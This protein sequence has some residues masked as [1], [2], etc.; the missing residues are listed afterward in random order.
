LL[1]E[2]KDEEN[3]FH[4][5]L[6]ELQIKDV[7]IISVSGKENFRKEY[8][9][10]VK[11]SG[12]TSV[13][14]IG[15]VRDAEEHPAESSFASICSIIKKNTPA[16]IVPEKPGE[17]KECNSYKTGIYIMPDCCSSGM[18]ED[19][20]IASIKT[21]ELYSEVDGYICKAENLY[22]DT[23]PGLR[24]YSKYGISATMRSAE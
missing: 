17:V 4:A 16:V 18:L 8:P 1:V 10:F 9:A 12:F 24:H 14:T 21:T 23:N 5:L 3:F 2:G 6:N 13:R 22:K 7:Q 11:Q 20:C 19:L 15:F